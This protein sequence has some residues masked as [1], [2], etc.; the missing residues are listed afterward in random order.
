MRT[1]LSLLAIVALLAFASATRAES[2]VRPAVA[3]M[4]S[5]AELIDARAGIA[6][7]ESL[8]LIGRDVTDAALVTLAGMHNLNQLRLCNTSVTAA[9]LGELAHLPRLQSLTIVAGTLDAQGVHALRQLTGLRRLYLARID[10]ACTP[11]EFSLATLRNLECLYITEVPLGDAGLRALGV[12]N[13][14]NL[15]LV[16]LRS[17]GLTDASL[18]EFAGLNALQE[19]CLAG[20]GLSKQAAAELNTL[21]AL[22]E[23][24]MEKQTPAAPAA[25]AGADGTIFGSWDA[26]GL[27]A[28]SLGLVAAMTVILTV[29]LPIAFMYRRRHAIEGST[30]EA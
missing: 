5:D 2:A 30:L 15:R 13:M 10:L 28:A 27:A 29:S 24:S 19:L 1:I 14:K 17:T 18:A 6:R 9:G 11:A 7:A 8:T 21:P 4:H 26:H 22:R 3:P 12:P 23:L 16:N 20:N 25:E